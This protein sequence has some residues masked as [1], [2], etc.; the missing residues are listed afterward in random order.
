[1]TDQTIIITG[2]SRGLGAATARAAAE[3]G[4][5]VVIN[6]RSDDDLSALAQEIK[7]AGGRAATV[8]GDVSRVETCQRLVAEA[9]KRFDRLDAVI[10]NAGVIQ[11]IAPISNADLNA[12]ERNIIV[13]VLAPVYLVQAALAHLRKHQG[14]VINVSSGAAVKAI[15]GWGAYC[16]A[17]AAINHFTRLL[18]AEEPEITAISFRPGVVDTAMQDV[19][20]RQG[21]YG[22]PIEEH[23][24]F[25]SYHEEG[26]LLPPELPARSLAVLALYAPKAWS[27]DFI[28]W[29]QDRV[30]SLVGSHS[31]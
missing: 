28:Q 14:R 16:T 26:A 5:N 20:R 22:M 7:G 30:Q 8:P 13:N 27:G 15:P 24:R 18:A 6:A 9:I 31:L 19:I 25:V 23:A 3:M 1:M 4:A 21:E 2:A 10:N 29:D 11:P 17:K 12:W